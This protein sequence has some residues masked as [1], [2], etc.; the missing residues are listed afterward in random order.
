M[1]FFS[2]I[3]GMKTED[4]STEGVVFRTSRS[5]SV[6]GAMFF[7]AG[8]S[9]L[10]RVVTLQLSAL[11]FPLYLCI[12]PTAFVFIGIGLSILTYKKRVMVCR[13]NSRIEYSE[14]NLFCNRDATFHF[15]DVIH[16]E[17]FPIA[18]CFLS[19]RASMWTIKVYLKRH[20]GFETARLFSG[21]TQQA[22]EDA[23]AALSEVLNIAVIGKNLSAKR[24]QSNQPGLAQ[25]AFQPN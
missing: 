17:L 4:N 12:V 7:V 21:M 8:V 16:I 3:R 23:A 5:C 24:G 2:F 20:N 14:S 13:H 1:E 15:N 19:T 6:L 10:W 25:S 18:E 9:L 11:I 22:A